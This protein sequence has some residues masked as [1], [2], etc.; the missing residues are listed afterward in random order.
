M[1]HSTTNRAIF[2]QILHPF[3]SEFYENW[4][5]LILLMFCMLLKKWPKINEKKTNFGPKGHAML[6]KKG[7]NV[8]NKNKIQKFKKYQNSSEIHCKFNSICD[9]LFERV[10]YELEPAK[11][12]PNT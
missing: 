7:Q 4:T 10:V 9:L 1:G 8:K 12:T 11:V 2:F 6:M 5:F 3:L